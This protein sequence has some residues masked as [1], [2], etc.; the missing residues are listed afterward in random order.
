MNSCIICILMM[1]TFISDAF[2]YDEHI[3]YGD[4]EFIYEE[5]ANDPSVPDY[6]IITEELKL[7]AFYDVNE[8]GAKAGR[9]T[10]YIDDDNVTYEYPAELVLDIRKIFD[11]A[12]V[13]FYS[14]D[15]VIEYPKNEDGSKKEGHVEVKDFLYSDIYEAGMFDRVKESDKAAKEYYA[16]QNAEKQKLIEEYK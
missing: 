11:D 8:L 3:G 13:S 4:I 10:V 7:D 2:P 1:F 15:L 14:P 12:G 5:F 16:E 9:L 6:A